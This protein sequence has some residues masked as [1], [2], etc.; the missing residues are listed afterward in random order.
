MEKAQASHPRHS[1]AT[2]LYELAADRETCCDLRAPLLNN[3]TTFISHS[4]EKLSTWSTS[5]H[6][7]SSAKPSHHRRFDPFLL[8]DSRA[9]GSR[10]FVWYGKSWRRLLPKPQ[11][12]AVFFLQRKPEW[13]IDVFQRHSYIQQL[14]V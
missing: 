4:P 10:L 13:L 2:A 14:C 1:F 7:V 11:D 9:H 12:G 3:H 5:R 8:V 6:V